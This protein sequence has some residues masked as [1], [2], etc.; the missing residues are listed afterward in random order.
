MIRSSKISLKFSNTEKLNKINNFINE[1]RNVMKIFVDLLWDKEN[2]SKLIPKKYTDQVK[3][4]TWLSVRAIQSAAKQTSAI[5]RGTKKKNDQRKFIY[6]K[7]NEEGNYKKARKLK[8]IIEKHEESKP[9]INTIYPELDS[10]FIEIDLKNQTSFDGWIRLLSLGNKLRFNVPFKRTKHFNKLIKDGNLKP[11]IRLY[12]DKVTFNFEMPDVP[13]KSSGESI[14]I[15]VGIKK[16]FVSSDNQLGKEDKD[17]WN[18]SKIQKKMSRK[19]WGSQSFQKCQEHRKN[20]I[21]WSLNQLNL[22]NV[23]EVKIEKIKH[24]RRGQR[25]NRFMTY[26][27][28]TDIF[29]KL[30]SLCEESG[31]LIRRI[32]ST[33]T[34]QRC[35]KCGWVRK[36]NRKGE[37]FK[38]TS[39]GF[40][41]DADL[42]ASLNISFDLPSISRKKR[43]LNLNR[44]GFYWNLIDK[45]CIVP[46]A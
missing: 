24:L 25:N 13:K 9:D 12:K 22:D 41:C 5:I 39:C 27:T 42:N 1:Y 15:D 21:N 36:S 4:K 26:W 31:V 14:G 17:G 30:Q 28:Y 38:C 10:R 46:Y 19:K 40:I 3:D 20:F 35:S 37:Q 34:S 44:E 7:L 43:L 23:K 11:G 6:N 33:Y 45:E 18:L 2:I 16:V 29:G 8:K 32:T